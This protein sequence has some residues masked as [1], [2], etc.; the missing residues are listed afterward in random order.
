MKNLKSTSVKKEIAIMQ[1]NQLTKKE[2]SV[3]K[4]VIT[5]F[6]I[7]TLLSIIVTYLF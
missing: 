7:I 2:I 6:I 3:S 4:V 5:Y 1:S